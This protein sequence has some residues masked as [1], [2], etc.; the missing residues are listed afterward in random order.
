VNLSV[1]KRVHHPEPTDTEIVVSSGGSSRIVDIVPGTSSVTLL[2]A[3]STD[4]E[5]G[6]RQLIVSRST[7]ITHCEGSGSICAQTTDLAPFWAQKEFTARRPGEPR[8]PETEWW[9]SEQG[10]LNPP[11]AK[12]PGETYIAQ[13]DLRVRATNQFGDDTWTP[14]ITIR[15]TSARPPDPVAP[16]PP[17]PTGFG[18]LALDNSVDQPDVYTASHT[19]TGVLQKIEVSVHLEPGIGGPNF[20]TPLKLTHNGVSQDVSVH[21]GE[22]AEVTTPFAGMPVA[23]EWR[24]ERGGFVPFRPRF[25]TL[26]LS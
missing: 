8:G 19:G 15:S 24:A 5:S 22:A 3:N 13:W 9:W 26:D 21:Y 12:A 6:I 7:K 18:L 11:I 17:Q 20:W 10:A 4:Q 16:P 23:G 2:V 25:I 14:V 1:V